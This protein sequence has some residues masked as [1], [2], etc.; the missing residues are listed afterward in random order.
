MNG[1][2]LTPILYLMTGAAAITAL[3]HMGIIPGSPLVALFVFCLVINL[4][5]LAVGAQ[6]FIK[7]WRYENA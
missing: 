3:S 4:V 6:R 5:Y 1:N 7:G 2:P